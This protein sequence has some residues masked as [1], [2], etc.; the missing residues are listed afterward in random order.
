MTPSDLLASVE[1]FEG[2]E[3]P[4][5]L[6]AMQ[7]GRYYLGK[8][9]LGDEEG[10][11]K[12][13]AVRLLTDGISA[14]C[15]VITPEHEVENFVPRDL[16]NNLAT[17]VI[18]FDRSG[19]IEFVNQHLRK[20]LN[21]GGEGPAAPSLLEQI[22]VEYDAAVHGR[23]LESKDRDRPVV[24]QT[25]F[26]TR[27][28]EEIHVEVSV[29]HN[30][31]VPPGNFLLTARDL[32][33]ER[34]AQSEQK[35][36]LRMAYQKGKLL[37]DDNDRLRRELVGKQEREIVYRSEVFAALMRKVHKVAL[38]DATVL[39]TGETGT[40]KEL[41]AR[42]IHQ[43]SRRTA[44]PL[45]TVDCSSIPEQL[46]ESELFGYRKG[47]FTGADKDRPGRF[48]AADGGT[49]FLDEIGE[50]P[51]FL[52]S[53]LLRVLQ[54][55]KFTPIGQNKAVA[56]DFRV[57]AATNRNL[58]EEVAKGTFR[59]DLYYRL[60]IFP[61]HSIPLRERPDDIEPLAKFFIEKFNKRFNRDV[62]EIDGIA[63]QKLKA[64]SFPGNVRELENMIER[65]F[66]VTASGPL[67]I[68]LPE[69]Y[70]PIL[71]SPVLDVDDKLLTDF[72]SIEEHQRRYILRVLEHTGGKVS[73]PG[74][75]AEILKINP[76]TLYSRMK[77]LG[78]K[79]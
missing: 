32:T 7:P 75:A 42:T 46:I 12:L 14:F 8:L 27:S 64:H 61:I 6:A 74:G 50:M 69:A 9:R 70:H 19:R 53:R 16:L 17:Y 49:I 5:N 72:L 15:C 37:S 56:A 38:T 68:P 52:Q 1:K 2:D 44:G 47:A 76:Q 65:A 51:L 13:R 43:L 10:V 35:S 33:E 28:G 3:H 77:K 58:A 66:I 24:R 60:N 79:R 18:E 31:L 45:I 21:Y 62:R 59:S 71:Q 29:L 34:R 40:G 48:A 67:S 30:H 11:R 73:G 22:D 4:Y 41:I 36:I 78:I 55:G 39:I 57:I 26:R 20:R 25:R 63:L 54:D 23:Y